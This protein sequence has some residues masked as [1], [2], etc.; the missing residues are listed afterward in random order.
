MEGSLAYHVRFK[1]ESGTNCWPDYEGILSPADCDQ[2]TIVEYSSL[3]PC[4]FF[5]LFLGLAIS[6][7]FR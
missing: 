6:F 2:L 3:T 1:R 7:L 4:I 5:A